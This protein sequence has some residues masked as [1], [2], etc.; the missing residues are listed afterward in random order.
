MYEG[1]G[2]FGSMLLIEGSTDNR[3]KMAQQLRF[4][5]SEFEFD[6]Q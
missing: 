6:F 4:N 1:K 2:P 5:L 3:N